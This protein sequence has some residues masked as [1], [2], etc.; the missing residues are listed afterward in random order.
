[1]AKLDQRRWEYMA[2]P[3]RVRELIQA[4]KEDHREELESWLTEPQ[5]YQ[6]SIDI[7]EFYGDEDKELAA[8]FYLQLTADK[9]RKEQDEAAPDAKRRKEE[10]ADVRLSLPFVL[11][12]WIPFPCFFPCYMSIFP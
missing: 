12:P 3:L 6:R 7:K 11:S 5:D 10:I 4:A 1:M 8:L 2:Y 9:K